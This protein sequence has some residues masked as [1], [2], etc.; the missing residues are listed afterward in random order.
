MRGKALGGILGGSEEVGRLC[1][2]SRLAVH[3]TDLDNEIESVLEKLGNPE[4][5]PCQSWL[6]QGPLMC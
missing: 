2:Y 5:A 6:A 4:A 3:H 1:D